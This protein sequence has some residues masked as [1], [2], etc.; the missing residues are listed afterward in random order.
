[1][2]KSTFRELKDFFHFIRRNNLTFNS[3]AEYN[4]AFETWLED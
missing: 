2:R 3:I 4:S 1:M